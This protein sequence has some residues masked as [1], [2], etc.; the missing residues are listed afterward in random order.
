MW[1]VSFGDL[2]ASLEGKKEE[3][4]C[5]CFRSAPVRSSF[6]SH[7]N[8]GLTWP[9]P[10]QEPQR[11]FPQPLHMWHIYNTNATVAHPTLFIRRISKETGR[12]GTCPKPAVPSRCTSA[13]RGPSPPCR[14][15]SEAATREC[16]T[17][18]DL[19]RTERRPP[20][21]LSEGEADEGAKLKLMKTDIN[22]QGHTDRRTHLC[23]EMKL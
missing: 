5:R 11:T 18:E 20:A 10:E 8:P 13:A 22:Q 15:T 17:E 23:Q 16:P 4:S 7:M 12:S 3:Y 6:L 1:Q 14:R 9:L 2:A 21:D 19:R